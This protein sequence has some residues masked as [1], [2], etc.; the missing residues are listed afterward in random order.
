MLAV[1]TIGRPLD[2]HG[3]EYVP[4]VLK[5]HFSTQYVSAPRN[6]SIEEVLSDVCLSD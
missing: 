4:E 2:E 5:G 1:F 6:F 3:K